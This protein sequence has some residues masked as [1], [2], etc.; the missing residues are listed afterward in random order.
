MECDYLTFNPSNF[1][2]RLWKALCDLGMERLPSE[3]YGPTEIERF[4]A[5]GAG[6]LAGFSFLSFFWCGDERGDIRR[7]FGDSGVWYSWGLGGICRL[8]R[9]YPAC[10]ARG[11]CFG[12]DSCGVG[13][14]RLISMPQKK[15]S[16]AEV[17]DREREKLAREDYYSVLSR[18]RQS[19][20]D[21]IKAKMGRIDGLIGIR[22]YLSVGTYREQV[23]REAVRKVTPRKYSVDS[24]FVAS[25]SFGKKRLSGQIDLLIWMPLGTQLVLLTCQRFPRLY[26]A[27]ATN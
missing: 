12:C 2:S 9:G 1:E 16:A 13:A 20:G 3:F 24:G 19:I 7:V 15:R 17:L 21:E 18:I 10:A 25:H 27:S 11:I 22:H 5:G 23:I 6:V 4:S 8:L 26:R 14:V